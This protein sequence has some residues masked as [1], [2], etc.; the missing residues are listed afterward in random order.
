MR[1]QVE[2]FPVIVDDAEI[3]EKPF[4]HARPPETG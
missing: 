1:D 2:M 4:R 3:S